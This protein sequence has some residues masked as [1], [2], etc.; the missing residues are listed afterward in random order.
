VQYV[1][2][3]FVDSYLPTIGN[4][5]TKQ[6]KY[7]NQEYTAEIMDTAG[8]ASGSTSHDHYLLMDHDYCLQ[9]D[10]WIM[11][12]VYCSWMDHDYCLQLDG[13]IMIIVYC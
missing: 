4:T 2:G 12:I 10:G 11:I 5:F 13:W 9:L 6:V 8:Q 1:E 3:H 7:R